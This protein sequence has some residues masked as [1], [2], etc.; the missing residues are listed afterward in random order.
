MPLRNAAHRNDAVRDQA[1]AQRFHDGDAAGR[2]SLE[3]QCEAAIFGDRGQARAV[4]GEERLV[5]G[6]DML[7]RHERCLDKRECHAFLAAD[8]FDDD[9]RVRFRQRDGIGDPRKSGYVS[10]A[11]LLAIAGRHGD[12]LELAFGTLRQ[13]AAARMQRLQHAA[14]HGADARNR[15][16]QR[17]FW[18]ARHQ[19]F[20]KKNTPAWGLPSL[21]RRRAK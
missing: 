10:G 16:A 12:D 4:V 3:F 20:H 17:F 9:I 5:R 18:L 19:Q 21:K 6:D 7:P 2:R 14:A 13:I 15:D 11:F 1:F 8:Q